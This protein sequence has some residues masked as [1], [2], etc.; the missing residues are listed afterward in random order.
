VGLKDRVLILDAQQPS[1]LAKLYNLADVF[2]FPS[3]RESFG[4]PPLEAI[5]CGVPTIAMNMTSLPEV[6]ED[7]ALMIEGKDV[8]IWANAIE[9]VMTEK[10]LRSDLIQRGL[11]QAA[12][13][14]WQNCARD[15]LD[16]YNCLI[17]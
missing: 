13:L 12:K 9:K 10:T 1:I 15:T 2:V 5:S 7:G 6:L 3:E 14:T 4:A 11:K 17:N 8:A 16:V